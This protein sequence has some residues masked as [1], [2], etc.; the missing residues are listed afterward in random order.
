MTLN[1]SGAVKIRLHSQS[2]A[3][4]ALT[5]LSLGKCVQ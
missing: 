1:I 4:P 5:L 3:V 2:Q